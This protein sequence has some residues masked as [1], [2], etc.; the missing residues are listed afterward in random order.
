MGVAHALAINSNH[1]LVALSPQTVG[2]L[3]K[4]GQKLNWVNGRKNPVKRVVRGNAI[5][6]RAVLAQPMLL[7][8]AKVRDFLPFVHSAQN[9][10]QYQQQDVMQLVPEITPVCPSWFA[11]LAENLVEK[12]TLPCF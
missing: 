5:N 4:T 3:G 2:P 11:H 12:R 6:K 10:G 1:L 8:Q 9:G 7:F